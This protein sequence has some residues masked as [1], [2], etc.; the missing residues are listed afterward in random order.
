MP[1]LNQLHCSI[2][3]GRTNTLMDEYGIQYGDRSVVSYVPIP[4]ESINFSIHLTSQGYIAPGLAMFVYIDGQYQCNRNKSDLALP[5]DGV[6]SANFEI[7]FRVRQ[8]E[9]RLSNGTLVGR[10]WSFS[11]INISE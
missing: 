2:E 6:P 5:E 9:E 1:V 3:L 11:K 4:S 10:D 8:K 7:D